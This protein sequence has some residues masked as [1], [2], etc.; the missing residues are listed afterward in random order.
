MKKKHMKY[1]SGSEKKG[2]GGMRTAFKKR[3]GRSRTPS[4]KA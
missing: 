1:K 3:S 4:N 2:S